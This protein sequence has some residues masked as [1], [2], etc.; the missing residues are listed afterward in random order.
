MMNEVLQVSASELARR[1]RSNEVSVSEVVE[2][3]IQRIKQVNP[4]IN[5]VVIPLYDEARAA[6]QEADQRIAEQG[7]DDLPPLFG[8]PVTV[9][10]CWPLEG[11]RFTGGTWSLR[12]NVAEHD[13]APVKIL[14]DAGAIILGKTNL[15]D[16]CW[17]GESSN[18][19]FGQ[20]NNPHN[21]YH[22]A[23]GSS[24]GEGS[25]VAAG[26]SALGLGSDIAGSVRIPAAF[27]GCVSLKPSAGRVPSE[28]HYPT[29]SKPIYEWN[30]AGPLA[31]RVEDLALFLEIYSRTEVQDY[32]SIGLEDRRCTV[33]IHNGTVPVH[34]EVAETVMLAAGTLKKAGMDVVR[35]DTLPV[36][37]SLWAYFALFRKHGSPG[38]RKALGGGKAYDRWE[39]VKAH[40]RG[41]GRISAR[42]LFFTEFVDM[43]GFL[44]RMMGLGS[45]ARLENLRQ[46]FLG[47]MEPGGVILTLVHPQ[48]IPR[49]NWT[50]ELLKHPSYTPMFNALGFPAAVVP[51]RYGHKHLPLAV[52]VVA[53]PGEDEVALAVAAELERVYG[54]W[55][56]ARI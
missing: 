35:D 47:M 1:I 48:P 19:V 44:G 40:F 9:K 42:V 49:H 33:Y 26:G 17:M 32:R 18:P 21:V 16:A 54:G 8:V 24:G 14:K 4:H 13:A 10:D 51:I 29:P 3:H 50:W 52:Q 53:R 39:E 11:V 23:G 55:E 27:N 45:F 7:T 28:D 56:M 31:R 6:A 36:A 46:R 30:T 38:F 15:P 43:S 41:E 25:V 34:H 12:D 37:Q 22:S 20:T 2:A 5:A